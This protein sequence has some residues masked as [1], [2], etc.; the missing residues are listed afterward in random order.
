LRSGKNSKN[1]VNKN[2][3]FLGGIFGGGESAG[4]FATDSFSDIKKVI[5]EKLPNIFVSC[6]HCWNHMSMF[7]GNDYHFTR[8][9]MFAYNYEDS[10][11]I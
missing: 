1:D 7:N 6:I 8:H 5:H 3:G 10:K 9:G 11:R 4:Y 2:N